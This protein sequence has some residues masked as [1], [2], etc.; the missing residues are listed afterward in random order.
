METTMIRSANE[1]DLPI[2]LEFLERANLGTEGLKETFEY[3]LLLEDGSGRLRA[4]IG[5]EPFGENGLLRSL[6]ISPGM[7]EKEILLLFEQILRLTKDKNMKTLFLATNKMTSLSFFEMLGFST[8][9]E[10]S[11][12]EDLYESE[13]IKNILHVDNSV[14]LKLEL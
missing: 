7:T 1:Q 12:P 9:L 14:F 8:A 4:T 5:V 2:L 10:S 3:F 11:L 13:H 6:V